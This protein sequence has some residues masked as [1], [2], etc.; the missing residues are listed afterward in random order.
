MG[1]I[2]DYL[3]KGSVIGLVI[4]LFALPFIACMLIWNFISP[5]TVWQMIALFVINIFV[6]IILFIAEIII[7]GVSS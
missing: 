4:M 2:T 5:V 1:R 7:I 3:G 6:Y